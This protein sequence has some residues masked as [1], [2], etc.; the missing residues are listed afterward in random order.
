MANHKLK[1]SIITQSKILTETEADQVTA[2]TTEGEITVLPGHV[3]LMGRLQTGELRYTN[4]KEEVIFVV[5]KGFIDISPNNEINILVDSAVHEREI[6]L[7]K[8]QDAVKAAQETMSQSVNQH[9]LLMAEASLKRAL[10][11]IR[12][13]QKTKRTQI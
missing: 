5:S 11:E 13:A 1:L 2:P 6:S 7:E 3:P 10:L 4:G 8:A 9:E 12:V